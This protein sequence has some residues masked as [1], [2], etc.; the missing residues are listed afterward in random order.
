MEY[1]SGGWMKHVSSLWMKFVTSVW[2]MH[3]IKLWMKHAT[4]LWMKLVTGVGTKYVRGLW[5]KF[6]TGV[7]TK[8]VRSR[9]MK[10]VSG[11]AAEKIWRERAREE[12]ERENGD[13]RDSVVELL[14]LAIPAEVV[15]SSQCLGIYS[16]CRWSGEEEGLLLFFPQFLISPLG[17]EF[18][19]R[20]S[21]L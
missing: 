21:G 1:V 5:M 16:V 14:S 7:W 11:R 10:Y 20:K 13:A 6:V 9:W 17:I 4:S 12:R 19:L 2:A 18:R 15:R 8:Y 3:V